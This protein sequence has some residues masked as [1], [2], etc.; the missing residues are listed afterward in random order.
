MKTFQ[1][2]SVLLV[3]LALSLMSMECDNSPEPDHVKYVSYQVSAELDAASYS[4]PKNLSNDIKAWVEKNEFYKDVQFDYNTG[5]AS[6]FAALDAQYIK[7]YE[8]FKKKFTEYLENDIRG[9]LA[10][11]GYGKD[12]KVNATFRL[13]AERGQGQDRVLKS[14]TVT[15]TYP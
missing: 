15:F 8:P 5:A 12:V 14:E 2:L 10:K 9:R 1:K 13:F 4:G 3:C 7:E 11:N 6:E